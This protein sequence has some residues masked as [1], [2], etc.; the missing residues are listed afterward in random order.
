MVWL[1]GMA[2]GTHLRLVVRGLA[3]KLAIHAEAALRQPLAH[4]DE[5]LD[6]PEDDERG[7]GDAEDVAD[8]DAGTVGVRVEEAVGVEAAG[9]LGHV[10]EG[11][12]EGEDDNEPEHVD[13]AHLV[14]GRAGDDDL[15]K[16]KGRVEGVLRNVRVGLVGLLVPGAGVEDAPVDD[17]DEP[18]VDS[19]GG[20]EEGMQRLQRPGEGVEQR[21]CAQR[22][23]ERVDGSKGKVEAQAPKCEDREEGELVDGGVAPTGARY[24]VAGN[25]IKPGGKDE[26]A[27]MS[28]RLD[29]L[30]RWESHVPGGLTIRA[31]QA[32][33]THGD[34]S[35]EVSKRLEGSQRSLSK[36]KPSVH[37]L[38]DMIAEAAATVK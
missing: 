20:V 31:R 25:Q 14:V 21:A 6:G 3:R 19:D 28:R 22:V 1:G 4:P 30:R 32:K 11:E 12:V 10:G 26:D 13:E 35:H 24:A 18:R 36:R 38:R 9:G 7:G 34:S 33:S 5:A 16:S 17:G 27:L 2:N 15:E 29:Q 8:H 37:D 23:G